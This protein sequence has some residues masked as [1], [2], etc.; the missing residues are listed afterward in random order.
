MI[1][2][3]NLLLVVMSLLS[4]LLMTF[5]LPN[6]TFRS[7]AGSPEA[8]GSPLIGVS[9]LAVWLYGTLMLAERR[10][11]LII[12]LVGSIIDIGMPVMHVMFPAGI[13][14]GQLARAGG[15]W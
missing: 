5:H 9:I 1:K 14:Q 15:A 7:R 3:H 11:G 6:D 12:M 13:F 4:I 10:S 2:N 8:G